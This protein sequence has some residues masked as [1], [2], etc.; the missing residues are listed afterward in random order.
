[1]EFLNAF[2]WPRFLGINSS[3]P[4]LAFL[5]G[6]S[7]LIFTFYK[8]LF[9]HRLEFSCF[10]DFLYA[11]LKPEL[12]VVFFKIPPVERLWIAWNKKSS[13]LSNWCTRIPSLDRSTEKVV[14][15]LFL[16]LGQAGLCNLTIIW[17][18]HSYRPIQACPPSSLHQASSQNLWA[19]NGVL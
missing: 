8:M 17:H 12:S 13:P 1:M 5:T 11:F 14:F 7:T 6:F 3:L 9:M 16:K 19:K 10:A 15:V 18:L 2:F 4:G